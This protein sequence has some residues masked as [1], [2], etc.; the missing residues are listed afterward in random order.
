MEK[1]DIE[2]EELVSEEK[3]S[4]LDKDIEECKTKKNFINDES[5]PLSTQKQT[6]ANL[7][8]IRHLELLKDKYKVISN[9]QKKNDHGFYSIK[10]ANEELQKVTNSITLVYKLSY[11]IDFSYYS[12]TAL[13]YFVI[14]DLKE[15]N[16]ILTYLLDEIPND[17]Y[18]K[19]IIDYLNKADKNFKRNC[20]EILKKETNDL[21]REIKE[22]KQ[23][24][25]E[26]MTKHIISKNIFDMVKEYIDMLSNNSK[27]FIHN[28]EVKNEISNEFV[29]P[30]SN[31]YYDKIKRL[32]DI[33]INFNNI[34]EKY[35]KAIKKY[36]VD[37]SLEI[38]EKLKTL[39]I[40]KKYIKI[41]SNKQKHILRSFSKKQLFFAYMKYLEELVNQIDNEILIGK[42]D[43]DKNNISEYIELFDLI[44]SL[45]TFDKEIKSY[46]YKISNTS[47]DTEI[48][49]Y[50]NKITAFTIKKRRVDISLL[51]NRF[52]DSS[53]IDNTIEISKT[54]ENT[55]ELTSNIDDEIRKC[56]ESL[57]KCYDNI[58]DKELLDTLYNQYIDENL[59]DTI[60]FAEYLIIKNNYM[61][62]KLHVLK[63]KLL[64]LVYSKY[65][66]SD[67]DI[68]FNDY[69][70]SN[71]ILNIDNI[72]KDYE[73]IEFEKC[74]VKDKAKEKK[75]I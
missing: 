1:F 53:L 51:K 30:I 12:A 23:T 56:N 48:I 39:Y 68:S 55:F 41:L 38:L 11:S 50:N 29:N 47:V 31:D 45:V 8:R 21:S 22:I 17:N 67:M 61:G 75:N 73:V 54:N 7:I 6:L 44:N 62:A 28:R 20:E 69:L 37:K 58:E 36:D 27:D 13:N 57:S 14:E 43:L 46:E 64:D 71:P 49:S 32:N 60:D 5:T 42:E 3:I 59:Q 40:V 74:K 2:K 25:Q 34:D 15:S 4:K 72:I 65:I 26:L 33:E 10:S 66:Q 24:N 19:K 52:F 9:F 35:R 63:N 70:L 16:M 18:Y